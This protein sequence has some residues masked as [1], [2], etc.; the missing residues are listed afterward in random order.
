LYLVWPIPYLRPVPWMA[1]MMG[2]AGTSKMS[3]Y[4]YQTT[5]CNIPEDKSSS[6]LSVIPVYRSQC[7]MKWSAIKRLKKVQKGCSVAYGLWWC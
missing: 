7:A 5:L 4:F 6:Y 3:L 1:L 2:A